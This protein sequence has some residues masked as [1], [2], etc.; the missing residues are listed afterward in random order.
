[1]PYIGINTSLSQQMLEND[2]DPADVISEL[3]VS[4]T[5]NFQYVRRP[6]GFLY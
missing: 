5:I 2:T 6:Y 3:Q 4:Y 1:M